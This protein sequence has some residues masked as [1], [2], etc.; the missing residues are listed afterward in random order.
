MSAANSDQESVTGDCLTCSDT[1]EATVKSTHKKFHKKVW[2][3]CRLT[4]QGLQ[5]MVQMAQIGKSH[6]TVW[7][8]NYRVVKTEWELAFNEDYGS[9]KVKKMMV[10]TDQLLCIKKATDMK[11][12]YPWEHE[13]EVQGKKKT[14]VQS[15]KLFHACFY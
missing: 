1:E 14:L 7:W 9:F 15:Q 2:A 11:N 4:R 5:K 8:S 13:A 6:Q 10:W 3:S 12:I